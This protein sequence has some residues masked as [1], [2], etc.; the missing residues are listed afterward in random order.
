MKLLAQLLVAS[1]ILVGGGVVAWGIVGTA[2]KIQ[3]PPAERSLPEVSVFEAELKTA[4]ID[5]HSQGT[6]E[7]RNK[8][9]LI[10][11][12]E[13]RIIEVSSQFIGGGLFKRN[14]VLLALDPLDYDVSIDRAQAEVMAARYRLAKEEAEAEQAQIDWRRLGGKGQASDLLSRRPQLAEMRAQLASAE[15][16]LARAKILRR[17][18]VI[19]AP[20]DGRVLKTDAGFGQYIAKE[21]VLGTVFDTDIAEIRL[22]VSVRELDFLDFADG[23]GTGNQP[24]VTLTAWYRGALRGWRGRI[25]RSEGVIDAKT[26]MMTLVAVVEDPYARRAG[27]DRTPLP[28]GLFVEAVIEGRPL[29][30]LVVLPS[31]TVQD[32]DRIPVVDDDLRIRFRTLD[33]AHRERDRVFVRAGLKAGERILSAGVTHPVE[34]MPVSVKADAPHNT[35]AN[36]NRTPAS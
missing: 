33:I 7:A 26:G 27:N 20:F 36:I 29:D 18:T 25:V 24:A 9:E 15:S 16:E 23:S 28:L 21:S 6:V 35:A 4:R 34:G 13:G 31:H 5:V 3:A 19:R 14:D 22:P 17:R 30:G 32:G 1:V 10:A 8:I 11:E 12:V 2:P